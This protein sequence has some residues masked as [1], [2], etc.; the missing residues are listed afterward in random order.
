MARAST[1]PAAIP[2]PFRQIALMACP[3]P[4]ARRPRMRS[5][6][7][8][9]AREALY[10]GAAEKACERQEK[11]PGRDAGG[12]SGSHRPDD[13]A[14]V[15]AAEAEAV[16]DGPADAHLAGRVGHVVQVA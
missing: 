13:Q 5:A 14:A 1:A 2:T 6:P 12:A 4:G 9:S 7:R 11:A 3:P 8:H 16:G 15:V 10:A